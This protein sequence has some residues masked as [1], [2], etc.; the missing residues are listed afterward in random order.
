MLGLMKRLVV[1][2]VAAAAT[3]V[4]ACSAIVGIHDLP[5]G[6]G[7]AADGGP[8]G[9]DTGIMPEGTCNHVVPP[10]PPQGPS[11]GNVTLL[12]AFQTLELFGFD[13]SVGYDLDGVCT[14]QGGG[15]ESCVPFMHGDEHC[16]LPGGQD[17]EGYASFGLLIEQVLSLSNFHDIDA[18]IQAGHLTYLLQIANYNGEPDDTNVF[19]GF[20]D[21]SGLLYPDDDGGIGTAKPSWDGGDRWAVDCALSGAD[22]S[23]V[24]SGD[25]LADSGVVPLTAVDR[26]AYVTGGVLVAHL[27]VVLGLGITTIPILAVVTARMTSLEGGG[28]RLDGQ[29][30]GRV[31][32][33]D[34]F[35][36]IARVH[37]PDP[38]NAG[39]LLCGPDTTFQTFK[40][41]ICNQADINQDPS[42]DNR[43]APC[44][45]L[46]FAGPFTALPAAI[47]Y[48]IDH[49]QTP[50][51]CDG[52]IDDCTSD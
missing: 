17:I 36:A 19:V 4:L 20:L 47:G 22:C 12:E 52:A 33:H 3:I 28:Y 38:A 40:P 1:G 44:D 46:S 23:G 32:T 49:T 6:D 7:G 50:L 42:N 15:P 14:C 26:Q 31:A 27:P 10:A 43:G 35:A 18:R 2:S 41:S 16:D 48:R 45:A 21:S 29:I 30:A 9:G 5:F 24:D 39:Q 37:D 13:A 11:G 25:W 34:V 51:G 8:P